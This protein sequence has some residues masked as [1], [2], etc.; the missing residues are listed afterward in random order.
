MVTVVSETPGDAPGKRPTAPNITGT[1][2][3]MPM[4]KARK[5]SRVAR[6]PGARLP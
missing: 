1:M 2:A 5:T 4:P 6:G 3:A